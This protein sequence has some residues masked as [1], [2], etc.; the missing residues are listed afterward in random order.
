MKAL[1]QLLVLLGT[2]LIVTSCGSNDKRAELD[3]LK[4]QRHEIDAQIKALEA[5]LSITKDSVGKIVSV[6]VS[7][8]KETPFNHYLEVQGTVDGEDNIGISAQ[9]PGVITSINVKEADRVSKGQVLAQIENNALKQQYES[10]RTQLEFATNIYNK[11]KSLWDQQI[12]SEIQYLTAKNNKETAEKGVASLAEQLEMSR[13]KS[14]INGTVEELNLKIGQ[15]ASPGMPA[16]RVVN[17]SNVKIVADIAEG[18]ASNVKPGAEVIVMI[19]DLNKEIKAKVDFTSKYINP[20]NR[21][22]STEIRLKPGQIEY[23]ANMVARVSILDYS[24]QKALT[25]PLAVVR[26]TTEGQYLFIAEQSND[27]WIAKRNPIK[28]GQT[29]NGIAEVIEG[30]KPGDKVIISG[31]NNLVDGQILNII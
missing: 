19:P 15:L 12:G 14:P 27:R 16:V 21:T 1:F 24:N 11:Q 29:Y 28:V 31:F 8:I 26:E 13:I 18:Y 30:L 6:Q 23:R 20:V 2:L 3:K 10:A 9:M 25:V 5:E 22:F 17:F 4:K 7:E